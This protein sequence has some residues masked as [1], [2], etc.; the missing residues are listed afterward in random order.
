MDD[1]V[2]ILPD[3]R[4]PLTA[5]LLH[6]LCEAP[7]RLPPVV[8]PGAAEPL[9]DDDFQLALY[10]LYEL[11]YRGFDGVDPL[12]EWEPSMLRVRT[13]LESLFEGAVRAL[14]G[15]DEP[16]PV[17][18]PDRLSELLASADAPPVSRYLERIATLD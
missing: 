15:D 14:A 12:W 2:P 7:H 5:V 4:G 1:G 9:D 18:V 16:A 3:A 8:V 17:D 11:H 13:R 6:E 10:V